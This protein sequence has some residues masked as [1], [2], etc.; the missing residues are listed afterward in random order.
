MSKT[1]IL[2][3]RIVS[4]AKQATKTFDNFASKLDKLE[5]RLT[6]VA[7][8]MAAASGAVIAFGASTVA[9]ASE[10]QQS[11]G[12][13]EAVFKSQADQVKAWANDSA[14][15]VGLATSEYQNMATLIGAQLKNMGVD[16]DDLAPKTNNLIE[17]GADLSA[18]YG[19]T[20][21][22]AVEAL[23]SAL[24]GEYDPIE[25]YGIAIKKS[26]INARLAAKGL[27]DLEGEALRLAETE[28]LLEMVT[29]QSGDAM[30]MFGKEADTVAGQ[31]QRAAAEFENAK[32]K[33]GEE[34]LPYATLAAEKLGELAA[35]AGENPRAFIMLG[36]AI[37]GTTIALFG[38]IGMIKLYRGAVMVF[39]TVRGIWAAIHNSMLVL[40][41]RVWLISA[42]QAVASAVRSV[43][44]W[45]VARVQLA[46]I[47]ISLAL[48][49]AASAIAAAAQWVLGAARSAAAWVVARVGMILGW[50][51]MAAQSVASGILAA[52]QWVLGAARSASAWLVARA[53]MIAGWVLMA[54]Q[55]VANGAAAAAAW[56]ASGVRAAA[57]WVAPRAAM[58]LA[59]A[60]TTGMTIAQGLLNAVMSANPIALV[61]LAIMALVA[62]LV[63]AYN[64]SESFRNAVNR[65][66][67]GAVGAFRR[68]AD[69][70]S[71][72]INAISDLISWIG[73][74]RFPSPP[75][76]MSKMF[77]GGVGMTGVPGVDSMLRFMAPPSLN[78][79]G[80]PDLTAAS[81]P[82]PATGALLGGGGGGG[83]T[84]DNSVTVN[85]DGSGIVDA[86]AVADQVRRVFRNDGVNR[87]YAVTG[88]GSI[89]Q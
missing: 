86:R 11:T 3:V 50:V 46:L 57:A 89:W 47:W 15:S 73:R 52:T 55:S 71:P 87:G 65:L 18:M 69:A 35:K 9:A 24:K 74:I 82:P 1:A 22:E 56:V 32:A 5:G 25:R 7:A 63:L 75:A 16:M 59:T 72:I 45:V 53:G 38:M 20:A 37:I 78:M 29:E 10:M 76:W 23:S 58:L 66:A 13:V 54:A 84:V 27:E 40:S 4:D 48:Q 19:G 36:G 28:A 34:L 83:V 14:Q 2:S 44:A 43:A 70:V 6:K 85:I 64:K 81:S 30:G 12:A 21:A 33:L 79:S 68:I 61:V 77:S 26:D 88:K 41:V 62:G 8:P 17:L 80:V 42:A 60:A 67:S 49:S 51:L 39:G 31:T